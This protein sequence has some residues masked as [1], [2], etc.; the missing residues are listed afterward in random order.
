MS[1]AKN[2]FQH[3]SRETR[4]SPANIRRGTSSPA[5]RRRSSATRSCDCQET[6]APRRS[7]PLRTAPRRSAPR[8]FG[9]A[10]VGPAQVGPAQVGPAQVGPAQVGPAQVGPA[11]VGPAQ[12][13][14]AQVGPAQVGPAQVGPAQV[15]PAQVELT[16]NRQSLSGTADFNQSLVCLSVHGSLCPRWRRLGRRGSG[17][18]DFGQRR[19]QGGDALIYRPCPRRSGGVN[20]RAISGAVAA[21]RCQSPTLRSY[22]ACSVS[23]SVRAFL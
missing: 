16:I 21:R 14:L 23:S 11:Q 7:A 10:Q 13:G 2:V 19:T 15:G 4:T 9:L 1:S 5:A 3:Q 12:V 22:L 18:V 6:A 8:R 20:R 17:F